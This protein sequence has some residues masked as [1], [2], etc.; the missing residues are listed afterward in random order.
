MGVFVSLPDENFREIARISTNADGKY[1]IYV[2]K[3]NYS[4]TLE[5]TLSQPLDK[6]Y[7]GN[8]FA[9][10]KEGIMNSRIDVDL[11]QASQTYPLNYNKGILSGRTLSPFS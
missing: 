3:D 1:Y 8:W 7:E 10:L 9:V 2:P 6:D 5:T 11:R 4:F